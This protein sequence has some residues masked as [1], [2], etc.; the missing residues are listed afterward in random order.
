MG[1]VGGLFVPDRGIAW[2]GADPKDSLYQQDYE[3][4]MRLAGDEMPMTGQPM[5]MKMAGHEDAAHGHP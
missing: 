2:P 5:Q 1:V 3:H 4:Y